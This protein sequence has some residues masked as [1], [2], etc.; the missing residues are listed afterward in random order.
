MD[1]RTPPRILEYPQGKSP[2]RLSPI[3]RRPPSSPIPVRHYRSAEY[4]AKIREKSL[5]RSPSFYYLSARTIVFACATMGAARE[6]SAPVSVRSKNH[7]RQY[8]L[9]G[10]G[11]S[12]KSRVRSFRLDTSKFRG[13]PSPAA[14]RFDY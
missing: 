1:I 3:H 4:G 11:N 14:P 10:T 7:A 6:D 5:P 13:P 12:S 9:R 2:I 8:F